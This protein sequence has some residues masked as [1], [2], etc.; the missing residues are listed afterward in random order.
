MKTHLSILF[1]SVFG[2]LAH[3]DGSKKDYSLMTYL[4]VYATQVDPNLSHQLNLPV[5]LYLSVQKVEKGSPAEKSGIQQFDLLLQLD[6]QILINQEQLKYLVRSKKP[7][8]EVTL[9]FLRQGVKKSTQLILGGIKQEYEVTNDEDLLENDL[10]SNRNPLDLNGFLHNDFKLQEL[11]PYHSFR[12]VPNLKH[13]YGRLRNVRTVDDS[14]EDPLNKKSLSKSFTRQSTNSQIMISD[15]K[16]TLEWTERDGQKSLRATDP[17]GKVIFDGPINT[18]E[19]RKILSPEFRDR[20]R[21]LESNRV[22]P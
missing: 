6:D 20:L 17:N 12:N 18:D 5:N 16:G 8:D 10:F 4:G 15:E 2:F 14:D 1:L 13:N 7:E 22:T 9:S 19:E 11:F 21:K 3:V